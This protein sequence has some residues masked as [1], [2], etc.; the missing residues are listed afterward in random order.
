M[1]KI[2]V[3]WFLATVFLSGCQGWIDI[4]PKTEVKS[5]ELFITEDG[6]KSALIGI[7]VRMTLSQTYGKNLSYGYIE[8]LAQRYDNY[9]ANMIPSDEDRAQ[10][11][12]YK[13]N[14][15]SKGVINSIW[16]EMYK[17]IANINNLI[18]QI[19][20]V[21]NE[22]LL[23]P[24][25][26]E[27]IEGEAYALRALHYF[28][29]LRLWGPVYSLEPDALVLPWR[30]RLSN[31]KVPLISAS[32]VLVKIIADLSHAESLLASDPMTF[33]RSA[34][35]LF[36]GERRFRMNLFAVKA[37][38]ARVFL[39]AGD[40]ANAVK[41][42]KDVVEN[43]G[44]ALI[45]DNSKDVSFSR[46]SLFCLNMFNMTDRVAD[47]W[48]VTSIMDGEK[49]ISTEN[50]RSV[51]EYYTIGLN[52][53]RYRNGY[54]FIHGTN[55]YMCRKYL[56][57]GS[58]FENMIPMIRLSEMYLIL[59]EA[60]GNNNGH[61][62]LNTLRNARGISRSSNIGAGLTQDQLLEYINKE[63]Q[64]EFFAE[65]Q[66]FYFLKR[67]NISDFYRCP[68]ERMIYYTLPLPDDEIEFGDVTN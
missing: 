61:I 9:S 49:W 54:G 42:A 4:S 18:E 37:L 5:K 62:Y 20:V 59:A 36:L 45:S 63:Y 67:H 13:N 8:E 65:G 15:Y 31:D 47:D 17:N 43:S 52:D 23:T 30:E 14:D 21:G 29:I 24:G 25:Y 57:E 34:T 2:I 39:Y 60:S 40:N 7:Y 22:V 1:K 66:W 46:E 41:Y 12:D 56:G 28:D 10:I 44:I 58:G 55:R 53:I 3:I 68:V 16:E 48:K 51:F 26:K 64:K 19:G 35:D 33:E 6:F 50:I 11:Y 32:E 27:I 38:L